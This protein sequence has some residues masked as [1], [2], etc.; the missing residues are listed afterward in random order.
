MLLLSVTLVYIGYRLKVGLSY[1]WNWAVI[2]Q[3][4]FRFDAE[5]KRFVANMLM[6]GFF[7]TIR[8]G[9]WGTI[10][11]TIV[12]YACHPTTLGGRNRLISPDYLGAMRETIETNTGL[13]PCL[14]LNGAAGELAPR[15]QVSD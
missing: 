12:N 9:V 2:P 14:F 6:E 10:L 1:K 3:Y 4:L 11:A 8:L 5:S 15:E 13:A 7:T